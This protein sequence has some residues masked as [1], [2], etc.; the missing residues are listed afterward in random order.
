[1]AALAAL[2]FAGSALVAGGTIFIYALTLAP[3]ASE[4][5]VI[6]ALDRMGPQT[7]CT[8]FADWGRSYDNLVYFGACSVLAGGAGRRF[9]RDFLA[10]S[11][12]HAVLGYTTD[13]NWMDSMLTDLLFLRRFYAAADPWA[14]LRAIHDSVLEDF[15]PARR[16]GYV[17]HLK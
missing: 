1:M 7:L 4:R 8:A 11:G 14:N 6:A 12:C 9:A 17:L 13:I 15:A 5:P 16:L 2:A 3:G 10:A